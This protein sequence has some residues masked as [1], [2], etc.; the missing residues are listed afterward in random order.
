MN[1]TLEQTMFIE[2]DDEEIEVALQA[3]FLEGRPALAYQ[4]NGDPGWPE[5]PPEIVDIS[6][7][8]L[9]GQEVELTEE[10]MEDA[11]DLL[12]EVVQERAFVEDED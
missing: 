7:Q 6:A 9:S 11:E 3:T 5:D 4:S 1:R 8:D 12:W 2:R 10:E